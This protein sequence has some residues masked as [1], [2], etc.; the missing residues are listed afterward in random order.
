MLSKVK[1]ALVQSNIKVEQYLTDSGSKLHLLS[2]RLISAMDGT[3]PCYC[4]QIENFF[5]QSLSFQLQQALSILAK[6]ENLYA[7]NSKLKWLLA[8]AHSILNRL[9]AK[10]YQSKFNFT[11]LKAKVYQSKWLKAK[12]LSSMRVGNY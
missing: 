4:S 11:R 5:S 9:K 8:K 10:V 12:R 1:T 6:F 7:L 2:L 3:I